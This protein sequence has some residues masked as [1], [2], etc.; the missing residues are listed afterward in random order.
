MGPGGG[1]AE[2]G[3]NGKEGTGGERRS[4][5][6]QGITVVWEKDR[7]TGKRNRT[8]Q[9]NSKTNKG[10]KRYYAGKLLVKRDAPPRERS[11]DLTYSTRGGREKI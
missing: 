2:G 1:G 10:E 5:A 3:K 8:K 6:V 11:R 4:S 7:A 9:E